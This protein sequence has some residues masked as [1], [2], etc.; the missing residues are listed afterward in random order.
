ML[1]QV[2]AY[3]SRSTVTAMNRRLA[4]VLSVLLLVAAGNLRA[5]ET[6]IAPLFPD[7]G[8]YRYPADTRVPLAQQ[9]V[10]QGMLLVYGFNPAE[11]ARSFAAATRA[12]P[13]CATCWWGLAWA[14]GP[15]INSD[16]EP[17]AAARVAAALRA[18]QQH[19]ARATPAQR[20]LIAAL[21]LRHPKA[22]GIDEERYA[23]AMERLAR[24][25]P[26][27]GEV[28]MLAAESI[29]NLH[30]Y[31]WW[32]P[33]GSAKPWTLEIET[34]LQKALALVPDHPGAHHYRI[35]LLESS[36]HPEQGIASADALRFRVPG[37]G[38]LS[39]MPAHIYLRVGRFD[40]AIAASQR[41][42]EA[43][44]RYLAG[45]DAQGAYRVG[46]VAHNHHFLYASA[47]MAGR[48]QLAIDA[49][50]AA[51]PAACGP[52]PG[53]R[54]SAILQHYYVL[55]LYALV[56][57]GRWDQ[58]LRDTL[59]PDVAEPYPLAI[60][61]YARG[62]A[63][64]KR[65]QIV[66]AREDLARLERYAADPS[67]AQTRIKN[68]NAAEKLARIAVLTL[69]ADIALAERRAPEAV[70]LL[71]EATAIED[72]LTYDEP[73]LWLAPTRH[74]LGE[75]LLAADRPAEA[76][77]VY[78]EDLA[79][80]PDNGWSLKG[81]ALAQKKQGRQAASLETEQEMRT[82][83]RGADVLPPASRF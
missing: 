3:S 25:F 76:E 14:L 49:A 36:R 69:R 2:A 6:P 22:G 32:A 1:Q 33:D 18:A 58:L 40:E 19:A 47:A 8:R 72:G 81:L 24:Q 80:Y 43:D 67:L 65:G 55:P 30:P 66:P 10:D 42:I 74:A 51:W 35:H 38:H 45:V 12:D 77:R 71:V 48:A 46:Y 37:S 31:D 62:T 13:K 27:D 28:A 41:S 57:F 53:D 34:L 60:W 61:H 4:F 26:D 63:R 75:A 68:I 54:S 52:R 78:R 9:Y 44:L 83:F 56:R 7:L 50:N 73:H 21:A 15:N 82:A 70:A 16:M 29:L 11:A 39:H 79:H 23:Q 5:A 20:G 64:A 59:P 17:A